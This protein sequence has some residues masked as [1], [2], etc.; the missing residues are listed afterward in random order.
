MREM[1]TTR[2][3]RFLAVLTLAALASAS[4][5][6]AQAPSPSPAPAQKSVRGKLR[7]VDTRLNGIAMDTDDGKPVAWRFNKAVIAEAAKEKIGGPVIVIYRLM[8][9]EDKR[10]TAIA[11]PDPTIKPLYVN[12]T[13]DRVLLRTAP[14]AA[15]GTCTAV[16]PATVNDSMMPAGGRAEVLDGCWCCAPAAETCLPATRTGAGRAYLDRCFE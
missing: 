7:G 6:S 9:P 3:P 10:V 8:G 1:R 15:D 12:L 4:T 16:D 11:F 2:L 14:A 5:T 13:G